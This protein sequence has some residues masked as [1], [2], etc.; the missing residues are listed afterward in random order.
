MAKKKA[1]SV[2]ADK[3]S[4]QVGA[5]IENPLDSSYKYD[6]ENCPVYFSYN[7]VIFPQMI[8]EEP[9]EDPLRN[10]LV[11]KLAAQKELC[12][13]V[14]SDAPTYEMARA[15]VTNPGVVGILASVNRVETTPEGVVNAQFYGHERV[16]LTKL[17]R[18][19]P[20]LKAVFEPYPM[21]IINIDEGEEA[22]LYV[23]IQELYET[24]IDE[25]DPNQIKDVL[26]AWRRQDPGEQKFM[27]EVINSPLSQEEKNEII[28]KGTALEMLSLFR[29][30]LSREIALHTLRDNIHRRTMEELS[31]SQR[32]GYLNQQMNS[33]RAEL[34]S[35][36]VPNDLNDIEELRQRAAAK[37]W[38]KEVNDTVLKEI[39]RLERYN[40]TS[41]DYSIQYNYIDT[42]LNLP[43]NEYSSKEIDLDHVEEILHRDHYG[44]KDIKDRIIEQMA[45]IKL[46]N[47]MKAP[48]LCLYG[49]PGIGKTSVCKSIA[50]ALGREYQRV[51]LGGVHDETE[52]RGHRRT[53]I[54]A[55]PGRIISAINKAGTSDPVIV[56]DEID[57]LGQD[58][59]GDPAMALLELLDG[60]QN[61]RFHDNFV[62][63]DYDMSKVLFIA[64]TNS[65]STLPRPLLD[66]LEIIEMSGYTKEEKLQ[67]AQRH[68]VGKALENSGFTR[69]DIKFE[70]A[71]I[72][73]IIENY[74]R[75]SGV[76]G[77]EKKLMKILR[78]IARLKA[79]GKEYPKIVTVE[80]IPDYLGKEEVTHDIY[81]NNDIVGVATG[82]AWTQVGGE[83][84]FIE[85]SI[86]PG[87]SEKLTLT[88]NLGDVMKESATIALQYLKAH[89]E[90]LGLT[91]ADFEGK[92]VH[93]H[94][95]EGATP[96]DGPS[97]GIT[98]TTAL[99]SAFTGRKV[100]EKLAMTGEMTLR[101]KVL[102]VGGIKEKMLAAKNAGINT[103]IISKQNKK[104]ID[105]IFEE[106]LSDM[107][108]HF[109]DNINEVLEIALCK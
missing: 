90:M 52:I 44:M 58:H 28:C 100:K 81:E 102:P 85:A 70:D 47:D 73:K 74:T 42:L 48:V 45:L 14:Y 3:N 8:H 22:A 55:M 66:R 26:E 53:Y 29:T 108:F 67:I 71:A 18:T 82:L 17:R 21:P 25:F 75:E 2:H 63:L 11:Y 68:L 60:E 41:P 103:I 30:Y 93:I 78:K 49:P 97:A 34:E 83:I 95:P 6:P 61:N 94:V 76:R 77:L 32:E 79:S 50:E 20:F 99:A 84:L 54:G 7:G 16:R 33:I 109:V 86:S 64:T 104:D 87:K 101:G 38:S 23:E 39:K 27:F 12:V 98:I 69:D 56:L 89:Q 9:S 1:A 80:M 59:R 35:M 96:K 51:A 106:Y 15:E 37:K 92:D 40:P 105:E 62:D 36:G 65:L 72:N 43:W 107:T 19:K 91:P 4:P 46:R 5:I 31:R 57:K 24:L 10:E 88:G 13:Y